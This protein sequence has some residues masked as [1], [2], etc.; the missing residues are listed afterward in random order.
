MPE[1]TKHFTLI[2]F[3]VFGYTVHVE[4]GNIDEAVL[5]Y[6]ETKIAPTEDCDG[7]CVHVEGECRTFMFLKPDATVSDVVHESYHAINRMFTYAGVKHDN[8]NDAYHLG[9]LA[10]KVFDY[11]QEEKKNWEKIEDVS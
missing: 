5:Q 11:V 10:G 4:V 3:P 6:P 7:L 2:Y 9:Y 8:E 1:T